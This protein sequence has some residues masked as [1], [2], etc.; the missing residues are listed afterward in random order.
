MSI[1]QEIFASRDS[2]LGFTNDP[3]G[4]IANAPGAWCQV[5]SPRR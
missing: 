3:L 1:V 5:V 2:G 4:W